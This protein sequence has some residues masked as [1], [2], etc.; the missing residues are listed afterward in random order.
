MSGFDHV[1]ITQMNKHPT[2][3]DILKKSAHILPTSSSD[4]QQ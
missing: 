1:V 4:L 3:T 2:L